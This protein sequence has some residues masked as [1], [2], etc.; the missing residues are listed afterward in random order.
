MPELLARA[1]DAGTS[2]PR[3]A[4]LEGRHRRP[5]RRGVVLLRVVLAV[6]AV[7]AG[8]VALVDGGGQDPGP[9]PAAVADAPPAPVLLTRPVAA[10][11]VAPVRVSAPAIDLDTDLV[12]IGVD[13]AGAL[14]PPADY[15]Q[16]GWF[17]AGPAPG[18]VGPAVLAGHV[19]NKSGP[20]V[21]F[22]LEEL[23]P[24]DQVVVTR[25]DGRPVPFTVTEVAA[26][27]KTAFPTA[28]V[29][30]PTAGAELRLITCG[31]TFDRSR[32]SYTDN[33]VVYAV[34]A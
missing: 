23:V 15:A 24:G 9:P 25:S 28:Q 32:R 16:A 2:V 10:A 7:T 29:Y 18:D 19:D 8:T 33:V 31:G 27:P 5:P 3:P 12:D 1:D 4:R 34:A 20:A 6:V 22:R 17:S 26:Y 11:V 21:F 14:V 13:A 30:G